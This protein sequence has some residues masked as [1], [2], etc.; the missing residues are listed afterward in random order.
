MRVTNKEEDHHGNVSTSGKPLICFVVCIP[1]CSTYVGIYYHPIGFRSSI[2]W[3]LT[4]GIHPLVR[5][6]PAIKN[7]V[8][9]SVEK[10]ACTA[11]SII[12]DVQSYTS[13][14][15]SRLAEVLLLLYLPRFIPCLF[16]ALKS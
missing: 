5:L 16:K 13:T 10:V 4:F 8:T 2:R 1:P 6:S 14:L 7:V 15:E 11:N 12:G 3:L 9:E